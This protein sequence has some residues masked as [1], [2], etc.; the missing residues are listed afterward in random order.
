MKASLGRV[1]TAESNQASSYSLTLLYFKTEIMKVATSWK[2]KKKFKR[3][4]KRL[5][6]LFVEQSFKIR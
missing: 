5:V 6:M 4:K 2:K 1:A 3:T